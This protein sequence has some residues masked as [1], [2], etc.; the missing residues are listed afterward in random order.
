[1]AITDWFKDYWRETGRL[2]RKRIKAFVLSAPF[3]VT[4]IAVA[5]IIGFSIRIAVL[6]SQRYDT[7]LAEVWSQGGELPYRHMA[8]YARGARAE[9]EMS[10]L[11][12]IDQDVS[13]KRGDIVMIRSA[14]QVVVDSG[15][16]NNKKAGLSDD[17]RPVGW[18]DCYSTTLRDTVCLESDDP[19]AVP[20]TADAEIV[21][22]DGNFKAFHPFSNMSGG[23]LP[24]INTDPNQVVINDVLSWRFFSSYDVVGRKITIG[25][26]EYT[27]IGVVA[28]PHSSIDRASGI[29]MP[30]AYIYF[31]SME[32]YYL[33]QQDPETGYVRELAVQCYEAMLPEMVKKVSITDIK[34]AIPNYNSADPKM[35]VVSVTDR[36][37]PFRVWDYMMPVGE[38]QSALEG[39]EFPYWEKASQIATQRIFI[40]MV[41][42]FIG[43][44]LLL[45]GIIMI[46]LRFKKIPKEQ[47]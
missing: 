39:Y 29:D 42:I 26:E 32:R 2:T 20:L 35:Y 8:V 18:E 15:N 47:N 1:M 44:V 4:L 21:G 46:V 33:D 31:T 7:R 27:I 10:P 36:F 38:T 19:N 34:N 37:S 23:F 43:A 28:E 11:T 16:P 45:I 3:W 30:R 17:G 25:T 22:I 13:L 9:G 41:V 24:E 5:L 12:Y 14:L 40:D 6:N